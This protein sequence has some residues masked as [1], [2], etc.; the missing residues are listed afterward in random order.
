M[1]KKMA[2]KIISIIQHLLIKF[3]HYYH[4]HYCHYHHHYDYHHYH[5]Y[6]HHML[7]NWNIS[8]LPDIVNYLN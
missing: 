7:L 5:H 3:E 2:M 8:N 4:H 6:H 1:V